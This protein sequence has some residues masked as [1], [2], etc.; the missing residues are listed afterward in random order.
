MGVVLHLGLLAL[1]LTPFVAGQDCGLPAAPA[2]ATTQF[3]VY[4]IRP[5]TVATYACD[6]GFILLGKDSRTCSINGTWTGFPPLCVTDIALGKPTKSSSQQGRI[7][8]SVAVNGDSF[9]INSEDNCHSTQAEIAPWWSVNLLDSYIIHS[10]RVV[11][12]RSCCAD[13][14]VYIEVRVGNDRDISR[15]ALCGRYSGIVEEGSVLDVRCYRPLRGIFLSVHQMR[16]VPNVLSLCKVQ[17]FSDQAI[18]TLQCPIAE[19]K[20]DS[21]DIFTYSDYCYHFFNSKP[22]TWDNAQTYCM[23][24]GGNLLWGTSPAFQAFVSWAMAHRYN[25]FSSDNP[26]YWLGA[27]R[28]SWTNGEWMWVKGNA[29][30]NPIRA[31]WSS[32]DPP[33][34]FDGQTSCVMFDA[35]SGWLWRE[36]SCNR[37]LNW[38][39]EFA[40]RSCGNPGVNANSTVQYS[41]TDV[42]SVSVYG[43]TGGLF[44]RGP[45]LRRCQPSGKWS[46]QPPV[47]TDEGCGPPPTVENGD[48]AYNSTSV[49]SAA[50]YTCL[51]RF[52]PVGKT[53][54]LCNADG[55]WTGEPPQCVPV[56][57]GP[58][59]GI[60]HGTG[61]LLDL[62]SHQGSRLE[63]KC[64]SGFR[65]VGDT[66]L[67]CT[68]NE[69]W[70]GAFPL[71]QPDNGDV[72]EVPV[73]VGNRS[74]TTTTATTPTT[75]EVTTSPSTSTTSTL[76]S[77]TRTTRQP[78]TTST[79]TTT[80]PT[81][82]TSTTTTT[83]TTTTTPTTT[84]STTTTTPT[85]TTKTTTPT[86]TTTTTT[87]T[88]TTT[89]TTPT[90]TTT[91][92]TTTSTTTPTTTTTTPTTTP[93]TTT[94]TTTTT[95]TTTTTEEATT[96]SFLLVPG[97][98]P[99]LWQQSNRTSS[100]LDQGY[101][102]PEDGE[103]NSI[104]SKIAIIMTND[105]S[106][107]EKTGSAGGMDWTAKVTTGAPELTTNS[108]LVVELTTST[109]TVTS[110]HPPVNT[111]VH[112]NSADRAALEF[113]ANQFAIFTPAPTQNA[114]H[115]PVQK[116]HF[117]AHN[118]MMRDDASGNWDQTVATTTK[119]IHL[120]KMPS[121]PV[122]LFNVAVDRPA[123]LLPALDENSGDSHGRNVNRSTVETATEIVTTKMAETGTMGGWIALGV[124]LGLLLLLLLIILIV[125]LMRRRR[126]EAA[127]IA[128]SSTH[129]ISA[130]Q[131][132]TERESGAANA[133][134]HRYRKAW[135]NLQ[136][137]VTEA[138]PA[139]AVG[140]GGKDTPISQSTFKS[141]GPRLKDDHHNKA[142]AEIVISPSRAGT[143]KSMG[144]VGGISEAFNEADEILV[145]QDTTM[146]NG[147][148]QFEHGSSPDAASFPLHSIPRATL[149]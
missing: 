74:G 84:T 142:S 111:T 115:I 6:P 141:T 36:T 109:T 14:P 11:I 20:V 79:S 28:S 134:S 103:S 3:D 100:S 73:V 63:Y 126:R 55:M 58:P 10:V 68:V 86:T 117:E 19:E 49:G 89:T 77:T 47:C 149:P 114:S 105:T 41:S 59:P 108:T 82:T 96:T 31:F 124:I 80:T 104:N 66:M 7:G 92:T 85:T 128:V 146:A 2:H 21:G 16:D 69:V 123:D 136:L 64:Q 51:N 53:R 121:P 127:R 131:Y 106:S 125:C 44:L 88:T 148:L 87:P 38:V 60:P 37:H 110:T 15:N 52:K 9:G 61:V 76:P 57:C 143:V 5:K 122:L 4:P 62:S 34:E 67:V 132:D 27:M 54:S 42:G 13:G 72:D 140:G 98:I 118:A 97:F 107:D 137:Q 93:S 32:R 135:D 119:E 70:E 113:L 120:T 65:I 81:T 116:G 39:C 102:R 48:V 99:S 22:D 46:D 130:A 129:I 30:V 35:N 33:S 8:S 43:C 40:P 94:T 144:S 56:D 95:P 1:V 12:G 91:T 138:G 101:D 71:C 139:A 112:L 25:Q 90:T 18:T 147:Q 75:T 17:A 23:R 26:N 83:T 24:R 45:G 145:D 78:T 133:F 29:T 50:Q